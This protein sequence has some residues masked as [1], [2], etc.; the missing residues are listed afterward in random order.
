MVLTAEH[1]ITEY[2]IETNDTNTK[3]KIRGLNKYLKRWGKYF[4]V[5]EIQT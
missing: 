1:Y 5:W 3:T 2:V 4:F